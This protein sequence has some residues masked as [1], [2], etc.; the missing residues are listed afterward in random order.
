MSVKPF[1]IKFKHADVRNISIDISINTN[2]LSEYAVIHKT[3]DIVLKIQYGIEI[4][5]DSLSLINLTICG[6]LHTRQQAQSSRDK[7]KITISSVVI[8]ILLPYQT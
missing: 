7:V 6:T 5:C 4:A 2:S 8:I 3:H 1:I